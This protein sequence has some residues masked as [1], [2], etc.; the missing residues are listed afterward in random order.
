[1]FSRIEQKA[2][3]IISNGRM[4]Q[5]LWPYYKKDIEEGRITRN[6]A[7]ELLECMWVDMA[8]FIDLYIN[9]KRRIPGRLCP[10]G[11]RHHRRPDS[12]GEDARTTCPTCSWNPSA[13]SP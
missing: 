4:D 8:Q 11:S 12:R 10:L 2:S 13:S 5:Y 3:A 1:M 7:K 9:P 6:E